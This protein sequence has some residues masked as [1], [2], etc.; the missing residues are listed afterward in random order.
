MTHLSQLSVGKSAAAGQK[1][2]DT[3]AWHRELW[4]LFPVQNDLPSDFHFLFRV[5]D[6]R[7]GFRVLVLSPLEPMAPAWARTAS[8]SIAESFLEHT[9]YRFQIKANPT[10]RRSSDRRRLAIYGEERLHKWIKRKAEQNGFDLEED[11]MEVGGPQDEVFLR[12]GKHGKHV[13]GKHVAVDF[14][15]VLD[16]RDRELFKQAFHK[17]IGSA[18][19]FGYGLLMLQPIG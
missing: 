3:Y 11:A 12:K 13:H 4:R 7:T 1:L 18:K 5:D 2:S 8:K 16:V 17:G 15:G 10:M 9:R 19:S 6:F 14:R